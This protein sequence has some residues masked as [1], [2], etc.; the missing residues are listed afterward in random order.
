[1]KPHLT[2]FA[3]VILVMGTLAATTSPKI[4][5]D[6]LIDR[7]G[8]LV[9][10]DGKVLGDDDPK[11][12]QTR[13]AEKQRLEKARETLKNQIEVRKNLQEKNGQESE[14]ELR[15]EAGKIKLKQE[16]RNASGSIIRKQELEFKEGERLHV[17]QQD[18]QIAEINAIEGGQTEL[19]RNRINAKTKLEL[20]V[21]EKNDILVTLPNGKSREISVPDVALSN[22]INNGVITQVEGAEAQYELTA[23]DNG[24][25]VY[26]TEALIEKKILGLSFLKLKF[27][28]KVQIAASESE[29]GSVVVGDIVS[30]KTQETNYFRLLLERLAR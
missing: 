1:M 18:G 12:E 2:V 27:A 8:T 7:S 13:E 14:Y 6:W 4:F 5:A 28:N 9:Q 17:E 11:M 23:G 29:D 22:L 10:V 30:S 26:E 19:I 16:V 21:N 25:P 20:K 24:E 15:T 3:L